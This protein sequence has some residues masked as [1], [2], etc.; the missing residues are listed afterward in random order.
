MSTRITK[1]EMTSRVAR[2]YKCVFSI[3]YRGLIKSY[4]H[5]SKSDVCQQNLGIY[6]IADQLDKSPPEGTVLRTTLVANLNLRNVSEPNDLVLPLCNE[7]DKSIY[8]YCH[9]DLVAAQQRF[10]AYRISFAPK[11][12][13]DLIFLKVVVT[14]KKKSRRDAQR[15]TLT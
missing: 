4:K 13:F 12:D 11:L 3:I 7:P 15:R 2:D 1:N 14:T 9:N 6:L 10:G 8:T 5:G